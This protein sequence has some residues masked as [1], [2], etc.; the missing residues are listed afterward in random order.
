MSVTPATEAVDPSA[1]VLGLEM[2]LL[3]PSSA[4][5]SWSPAVH[6]A[7]RLLAGQPWER[8]DSSPTDLLTLS[9]LLF[10]RTY[11]GDR[12]P[13]DV[14][15]AELRE[16]LAGPA[17]CEPKIIDE[18]TQALAETGQRTTIT[19][20]DTALW[21]LFNSARDQYAGRLN[22]SGLADDIEPPSPGPSPMRGATDRLGQLFAEYAEDRERAVAPRVASSPLVIKAHQFKLV[23]TDS[24]VP[25]RCIYGDDVLEV[26]VDGPVATLECSKGHVHPLRA[27]LDAAHVRMAVARATGSRPS[28]PGTHQLG[29]LLIATPDLPRHLDPAE[30]N[31]FLRAAVNRTSVG[32][33]T[34]IVERI[35]RRVRGFSARPR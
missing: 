19:D 20:P 18:M 16:A 2:S 32:M 31:V 14:P 27:R 15:V 13:H 6:E 11:S 35:T 10:A 24:I 34:G 9:L 26:H 30:T 8:G 33:R 3:L 1:R 25:L 22:A 5:A 28:A 21:S 4:P 17:D 23:S 7:A 12:V 29:E